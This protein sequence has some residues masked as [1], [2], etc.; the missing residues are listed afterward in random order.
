MVDM[1]SNSSFIGEG[2]GQSATSNG[3]NGIDPHL[4]GG[5]TCFDFNDTEWT[6]QLRNFLSNGSSL[7]ADLLICIKGVT[8]DSIHLVDDQLDKLNIRGR[9][10]FYLTNQTFCIKK[11]HKRI[12]EGLKYK[13]RLCGAFEKYLSLRSQRSARTVYDDGGAKEPNDSFL[14]YHTAT[15]TNLGKGHDFP[16][17]VIEVALS[18][19]L[20]GL[21][22]NI[23][24]WLVKTRLQTRTAVGVKVD[25]R[26]LRFV[27]T[28]WDFSSEGLCQLHDELVAEERDADDIE[29]LRRC[30]TV[31]ISQDIRQV[32]WFL[33]FSSVTNERDLTT[34]WENNGPPMLDAE[35]EDDSGNQRDTHSVPVALNELHKEL[36]SIPT[37]KRRRAIRGTRLRRSWLINAFTELAEFQNANGAAPTILERH[38]INADVKDQQQTPE[39]LS[40]TYEEL[41]ETECARLLDLGKPDKVEITFRSGIPHYVGGVRNITLRTSSWIGFETGRKAD[42]S[43]VLDEPFL[44]SLFEESM[45]WDNTEGDVRLNHLSAIG[46]A[47]FAYKSRVGQRVDT[48]PLDQ[49][50]DLVA[51]TKNVAPDYLLSGVPRHFIQPEF[52]EHYVYGVLDFLHDMN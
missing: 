23:R 17:I 45:F 11:E 31:I 37:P 1:A 8:T 39:T 40:N 20:Q 32:D 48:I 22:A 28:V 2:G 4:D 19:T 33:D 52:R 43:I 9:R 12:G 10:S 49:A 13:L 15:A 5:W 51:R 14:P 35:G 25:R 47:Y 29:F 6:K 46:I 30:L 3:D 38:I 42:S 27:A 36:R 26:R 41:S 7:E 16:Q 18:E 21:S 50:I 34:F 24:R 44:E